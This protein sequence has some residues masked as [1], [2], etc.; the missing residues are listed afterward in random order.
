MVAIAE[1]VTMLTY[2]ARKN[3]ANFSELYSVWNPP[4]SSDSAS[5]QVERGAVGLADHRDHE[6]HEAR[7]PA[8][9]QY[10]PL[11]AAPR[12]CPP[13]DSDPA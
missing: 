3:S 9:R 5:G 6:H 2:S 13:V 7:R 1:T 10:Q 4:T 11:P 12:R 8:G